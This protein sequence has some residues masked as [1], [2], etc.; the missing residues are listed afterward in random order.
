MSKETDVRDAIRKIAGTDNR[1]DIFFTAEIVS[2]SGETCTVKHD[3]LELTDVQLNASVNGNVKNL[4]IKPKVGSMVLVADM[5]DGK[6]DL[7]VIGWSEVE[8]ITI[9]NGENGGLVIVGKMNDWM[10]KVYND[11]QTLK[12]LLQTSLVAG[13]G[14]PLAIAFTPSTT[15]PSVSNFENPKIKH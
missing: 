13:N 9:N 8:T 10:Q 15:T 4:L 2:V 7:I 12:G 14:A 6:Q 11:L 5:G 1:N 3:G